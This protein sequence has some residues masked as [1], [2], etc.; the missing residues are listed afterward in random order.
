M[1]DVLLIKMYTIMGGSIPRKFELQL[2]YEASR[3]ARIG[4]H[5]E[6]MLDMHSDATMIT[7]YFSP[8]IVQCEDHE[9]IMKEK[10]I[11]LPVR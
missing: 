4:H 8:H 11:V 10:P 2:R 6:S 1:R 3:G 9:I 7:A 5:I